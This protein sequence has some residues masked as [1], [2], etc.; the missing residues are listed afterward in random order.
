[1]SFGI[2]LLELEFCLYYLPTVW[3]WAGCLNALCLSFHTGKTGIIMDCVKEY[4]V[5]NKLVKTGKTLR[6]EN[7]TNIVNA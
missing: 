3:S 6:M 7:M 1:M 5:W 4:I 2:R